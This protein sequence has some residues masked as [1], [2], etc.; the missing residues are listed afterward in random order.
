M[1]ITCTNNKYMLATRRNN[2]I[3]WS[4]S[5]RAPAE[6]GVKTPKKQRLSPGEMRVTFVGSYRHANNE[7][8]KQE[9]ALDAARPTV[10]TQW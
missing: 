2:E 7:D 9:A 3:R 8:M 6:T 5:V 1:S 10:A 4:Q